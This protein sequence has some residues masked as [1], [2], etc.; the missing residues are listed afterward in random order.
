MAHNDFCMHFNR[1][2]VLYL[3][4]IVLRPSRLYWNPN[5]LHCTCLQIP[6]RKD[7]TQVFFVSN[8]KMHSKWVF[9]S[10]LYLW[11]KTQCLCKGKGTQYTQNTAEQKTMPHFSLLSTMSMSMF[12]LMIRNV[13]A[14]ANIYTFQDCLVFH[15]HLVYEV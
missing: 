4:L 12:Q 13:I 6:K 5:T 11:H 7:A 14:N 10:F 2:W 9:Y 8:W 1:S 3:Q 15:N